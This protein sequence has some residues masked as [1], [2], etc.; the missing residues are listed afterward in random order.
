MVCRRNDPKFE[1][2]AVPASTAVVTPPRRLA[3]GSRPYGL[4]SYQ[5]PCRSTR[6]GRTSRPVTSTRR[7]SGRGGHVRQ[8]RDRRDPS[9]LDDDIE[10]AVET[11]PRIEDAAA[12]EDRSG[13]A[14]LLSRSARRVDRA[15]A[16][17]PAAIVHTTGRP[18]DRLRATRRPHPGQRARLR[19]AGGRD[20]HGAG[21]RGR[22]GRGGA[23]VRPDRRPAGDRQRADRR[24]DRG[25]GGLR[26]VRR[27]RRPDPRRGGDAGGLDPDRMERLPDT[28]G[29]PSEIVVQAGHRNPYDHLVRA[30]GARLVEFG[31][32]NGAHG[33][34]DGRGDRPGHGRRVLPRPG[35]GARPADRGVRGD[36]PRARPAGPRRRVDEPAAARQPAS[37]HRR[38][39]RPRRVQWRQDDPRAAGV[40]VPRRPGRPPHLGRAPAAGHGRAHGDLGPSRPRRERRH[41]ATADPR[42]RPVD[43]DRQ[44][45]DRR[46]PR[47]PRALCGPRRGRRDRALDRRRRPSRRR[48]DRDPRPDRPARLR[49]RPMAGPSR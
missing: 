8:R 11:G 28:T 26:H 9:V 41:P 10:G 49:P 44:G 39:R 12:V 45:G 15:G 21:G 42:H 38:R 46:A 29:G 3:I 1:K 48:P 19:D 32:A 14:T 34:A 5:W 20:A 13:H 47:R 36:R 27:G 43:E 35:G 6:P 7:S 30:S 4:P 31:D 24:A 33:G 16:S 18:H 17:A 25:R 37:L 2:P 40:R 22:H 23:L